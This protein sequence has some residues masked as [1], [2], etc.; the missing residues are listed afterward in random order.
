MVDSSCYPKRCIKVEPFGDQIDVIEKTLVEIENQPPRHYTYTNQNTR[1]HN[2]ASFKSTMPS[3]Q[4]QFTPSAPNVFGNVPSEM[5]R[6]AYSE[7][8]QP[9]PYVSQIPANTL[10]KQTPS[11]RMA[12][13]SLI[14]TPFDPFQPADFRTDPHLSSGSL[15]GY[16][17]GSLSS[18]A[19]SSSIWGN[20][21]SHRSLNDAAVWG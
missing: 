6:S 14:Y 1:R 8:Y 15:S 4:P 12:T 13:N 21:D 10:A 20:N 18:T 5:A 11:T 9:V 7:G 19:T 16:V 3:N 2:A 17:S